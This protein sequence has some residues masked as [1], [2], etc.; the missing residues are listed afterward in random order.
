M[1]T[2]YTAKMYDGKEQS[3]REYALEC[4]R[5]FGACVELREAPSGPAPLELPGSS[6]HQERLDKAQAEL[7]AVM[8]WTPEELA[9]K[10][11][12]DYQARKD[13]W[14]KQMEECAAR[15]RLYGA[16]LAAAKAWT[17]PSPDHEELKKF[18][19]QQIETCW[20]ETKPYG[21]S[22]LGWGGN[23]EKYREQRLKAI[24]RDIE[25]HTRQAR[26]EEARRTMRNS[27]LRLLHESL[28]AVTP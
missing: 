12:A 3:F 6:Y 16:N 7:R 10:A 17:P 2:G 26:E 25:H 27:W 15:L 13:A 24:D 21:E 8:A 11:E 22:P 23:Y 18:M 20:G 1:P 19:I 28:P 5:A 9:E 14:T 4:A